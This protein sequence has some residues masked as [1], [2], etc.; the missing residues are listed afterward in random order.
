MLTYKLYNIYIYIYIYINQIDIQI[1]RQI[2]RDIQLFATLFLYFYESKWMN[3]INKNDLINAKKLCNIFR[4]N[5][6]LNSM[7]MGTL[8]LIIAI[9]I[10]R[11][12]SQAIFLDLD[13][14]KRMESFNFVSSIK[15]THFVFTTFRILPR[16]STIFIDC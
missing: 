3:R 6:D 4:F 13:I 9:S 11:N 8:K 12:Q 5:D 14:R 2:E 10:L 7:M 1:D 16:N 15:Q